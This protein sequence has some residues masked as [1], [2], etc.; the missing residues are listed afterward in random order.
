[1]KLR[2]GLL[3]TLAALGT[4]LALIYRRIWSPR[5][6]SAVK[7]TPAK[8]AIGTTPETAVLVEPSQGQ[9]IEPISLPAKSQADDETPPDIGPVEAIEAEQAA[10]SLPEPGAEQPYT[11]ALTPLI[12]NDRALEGDAILHPPSKGIENRIAES[13][14][15]SPPS[16]PA[17]G[18]D[19]TAEGLLLITQQDEAVLAAT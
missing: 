9:S 13:Q 10:D 11:E 5:H 15:E 4:G 17:A 1:M 3:F 19:Q 18:K 12:A 6:I 7:N 16:I 2:Y 14:P 8:S